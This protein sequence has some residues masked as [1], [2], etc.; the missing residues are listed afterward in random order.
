M[1]H[2][3]YMKCFYDIFEQYFRRHGVAVD[4]GTIRWVHGTVWGNH[5][6]YTSYPWYTMGIGFPKS[7]LPPSQMSS[8][9]HLHPRDATFY[10]RT[11]HASWCETKINVTHSPLYNALVYISTLDLDVSWS[12]VRYV[13]CEELIQ[14]SERGRLMSSL[15]YFSRCGSNKSLPRLNYKSPWLKLW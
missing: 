12:P 10:M 1:Q 4:K 7:S 6:N 15:K 14:Y 9:R 3:K 8:S 13:L 11:G 5:R 2:Q